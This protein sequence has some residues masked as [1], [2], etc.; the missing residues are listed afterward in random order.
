MNICQYTYKYIHDLFFFQNTSTISIHVQRLK[1][2][3]VYCSVNGVCGAMNL[4]ETNHNMQ[5]GTGEK[6]VGIT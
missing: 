4:F 5:K 3:R 6:G 1:Q 2:R